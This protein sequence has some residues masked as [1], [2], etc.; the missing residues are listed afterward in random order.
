MPVHKKDIVKGLQL[1]RSALG[2]S[3]SI[4]WEI[5]IISARLIIVIAD[6]LLSMVSLCMAICFGLTIGLTR[7]TR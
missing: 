2:W 1:G 4:T 6:L 7:D 3:M 5:L